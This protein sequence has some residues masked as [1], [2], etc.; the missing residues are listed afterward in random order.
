LNV[1]FAGTPDFAATILRGLR[2]SRHEVGMVVSQPDARRGR[3]RRV[4][5][6]PVASL[7]REAGLPLAQPER[8]GDV[9][10]D[11]AR[12]DALVVAAYGQILRPDTLYA[13]AH[14]A[15]NV[16]AS[17]LPA[18]RG[19]APVERAI[20]NG[21]TETGVSIMRMDEGLDT[22]PV[23]LRRRIPI[24][25]DMDAGEL[26]AALAHLGSEAIVEVLDTIESGEVV[27]EEQE[28]RRA[29]YAAK[30]SG[31][32]ME[33][34]WE[35]PAREV[36]DRVRAL[37]PKIGARAY[38]VDV[39]GPIKILRSR[40]VEDEE[41]G[42]EGEPGAIAAANG[43]ILARCGEG[44]ISV[45]RLQLPGG[46]PLAAGDFLRGHTLEGAFRR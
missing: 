1:A 35:R 39:D 38:H 43:R 30:I 16:H 33:I 32:D 29:T 24:P 27:L 28:D 40:V 4:S 14:G 44:V 5:A 34:R 18:Y 7:A 36:H 37:A 23:A 45:E 41:A 3:G 31:E 46:R 11:I 20:L 26:T 21:E 2:G 8:I 19:A 17:V 6:S 13:A 9:A 22:G 10:P 42:P 15:W 25:P 12:Y